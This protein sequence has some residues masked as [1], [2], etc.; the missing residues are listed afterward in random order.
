MAF[1]PQVDTFSLQVTANANNVSVFE[2]DAGDLEADDK[3]VF[4]VSGTESPESYSVALLDGPTSSLIPNGAFYTDVPGQYTLDLA[5]SDGSNVLSTQIQT[6]RVCETFRRY[7][8]PT[9]HLL[10]DVN[11]PFAEEIKDGVTHA[12]FNVLNNSAEILTFTLLHPENNVNLRSDVELAMLFV[13]GGGLNVAYDDYDKPQ[14]V[15]FTFGV[16]DVDAGWRTETINSQTYRHKD[17]TISAVNVHF[18]GAVD[19]T[20]L[21]PFHSRII[22]RVWDKFIP[23]RVPATMSS[24]ND[25]IL[26]ALLQAASPGLS[27]SG[28][29]RLM[30]PAPTTGAADGDLVNVTVDPGTP[31]KTIYLSSFRQPVGIYPGTISISP[32]VS[33]TVRMASP[34]EGIISVI[35]AVINQATNV[36]PTYT[37]GSDAKPDPVYNWMRLQLS[38]QFDMIIMPLAWD[39][40]DMPVRDGMPSVVPLAFVLYDKLNP[41]EQTPCAPNVI[42]SFDNPGAG[43]SYL[44]LGTS[45]TYEVPAL[46]FYSEEANPLECDVV[47]LIWIKVPGNV[48]A[49]P[50]KI[51]VN[52]E[53]FVTMSVSNMPTDS[54]FT[55]ADE[56]LWFGTVN[57]FVALGAFA[58]FLDDY[59]PDGSSLVRCATLARQ[60]QTYWLSMG[61]AENIRQAGYQFA[62]R[63]Q[64]TMEVGYWLANC[65]WMGCMDEWVGKMQAFLVS[66]AV[67]I[68]WDNADFWG[69]LDGPLEFGQ[70]TNYGLD[71]G[72]PFG[73]CTSYYTGSPA[74]HVDQNKV[75]FI[76]MVNFFGAVNDTDQAAFTDP[77]Y[78]GM[79]VGFPLTLVMDWNGDYRMVF[80][81]IYLAI[82]PADWDYN[83][84]GPVGVWI[85]Q[86]LEEGANLEAWDIYWL[87]FAVNAR[88]MTGYKLDGRND[89]PYLANPRDFMVYDPS[90]N[91]PVVVTNADFTT[92]K[93]PYADNAKMLIGTTEILPGHIEITGAQQV[94]VADAKYSSG[95]GGLQV[96]DWDQKFHS[97]WVDDDDY[98]A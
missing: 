6:V 96:V 39:P 93:G 78:E 72:L 11:R 24:G 55:V 10:V 16:S 9:G 77:E 4:G 76:Y 69:F 71:M 59:Q 22:I 3:V 25:S 43:F 31:F 91:P 83:T 65:N 26:T 82:D 62:N 53:A 60:F 29:I 89:E 36:A 57:K 14:E 70:E 58:H 54:T 15:S 52:G 34:Y 35:S 85:Q 27:F 63:A 68:G 50:T 79:G 2:G 28:T 64:V 45:N 19:K 90:A 81:S 21:L 41:G 44:K 42:F 66:R 97:G 92:I 32:D 13:P 67:S 48:S 1:E 61:N 7:I 49:S 8:V 20:L 37:T 75:M 46:A 18:E 73:V 74:F 47:Y 30:G 40:I 88:G 12:L 17:F 94:Y 86:I 33:P 80:Q 5:V 23:S 51:L 84:Y 87:D 38:A 95:P 56:E 98:T